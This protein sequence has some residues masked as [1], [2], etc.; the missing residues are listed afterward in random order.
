MQ[1][2][3]LPNRGASRHAVAGIALAVVVGLAA[4]SSGD[5]LE[6]GPNVPDNPSNPA[7]REASFIFDVNLKSKTVK[8][9]GPSR[10]VTPADLANAASKSPKLNASIVG[11]DFS[12]LSNDAI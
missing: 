2:F 11:P 1:S 8:V 4:C 12:I 7:L 9:T 10:S 6:P 3:H 5:N